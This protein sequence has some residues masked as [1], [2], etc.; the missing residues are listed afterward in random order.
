MHIYLF[1][2][3]FLKGL[4]ITKQSKFIEQI[5][6][7]LDILIDETNPFIAHFNTIITVNMII[8]I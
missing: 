3:G 7:Y 5:Y 6:D 1:I 8:N 2:S 4:S